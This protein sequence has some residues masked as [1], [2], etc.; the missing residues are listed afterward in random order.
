M[1][2]VIPFIVYAV[3]GT[4][5]A[6]ATVAAVATIVASIAVA[7]YE[8]KQAEEQARQ[9]YLNSLQDRLIQERSGVATRGYVVGTVRVG[10]ALLYLQPLGAKGEALDQVVAFANNECDIIDYLLSDDVISPANFPGDKYGN[11]TFEPTADTFNVTGPTATVTL[12]GVPKATHI[13]WRQNGV[14]GTG[15]VTTIAANVLGIGSLP[16]GASVVTVSYQIQEAA[17]LRGQFQSG[18][19]TQ[20][21]TA[22]AGYANPG[23]DTNHRLLGV[24]HIRTLFLWDQ[25]VFQNGAPAVTAVL[26]GRTTDGYPFYDPRDGSNPVSSTNPAIV[27]GWWMTLP[28][29]MGGMGIPTSWID[30]TT[31]AAA[32]NICDE[33]VTVRNLTNTAYESIK[34]Y[35]CDTYLDTANSPIDNLNTILSSMAGTRAFTSGLYK[36]FAGAFRPAVVTLTDSDIVG[37]K[38]ISV[39]TANVDDEPPNV[40]TA[41]ISDANQIWQQSNPTAV[42]NPDYITAD[43]YENP[44]DLTLNATTDARRARYLMGIALERGRPAF[45][46]SLSIAGVGETLGLYDTV[47][48]SLSNRSQYAG[49]TYEIVSY[50]DN[51]DGTF[52]VTLSEVKTTTF[53]LDPDTYTP[54]TP[55][56]PVDNSYLWNPPEPTTFQ[57]ASITPTT[58]PDGTAVTRVNLTWDPIPP[59]GNTPG[60][61]FDIRYRTTGGDFIDG[62]SV[63]GDSTGT[64][65]TANLQ[66][67]EQYQFELRFV[68]GLGAVSDWVDAYTPVAGT[69]LPTP[70]SM[71]ISSSSLIFRVPQTGN[72]LP[73]S[74]TLSLIR[75]G[76]LSA[77]AT[78]STSPTV[79]LGGS[80]D[81]RTLSF[82]NDTS[83]TVQ[84]TATIVQSGVTYTDVVTI[85]K[86]YDGASQ[87]ADL[88]APPTPTGLTVTAF[89]SHLLVTWDAGSFTV[90]HGYAGTVVYAAQVITG[91]T[92]P[93]FAN[94]KSI[95]SATATGLS[96][97]VDPGTTW[98]IWI[99]YETNDGVL[100][101]TPAGG[102]NGVQGT[103]ALIGTA[104]LANDLITAA[105]LADGSVGAAQLAAG[106]LDATKFAA[107]IYPVVIVASA[108]PQTNV[109]PTVYSVAQGVLYYWNGSQYSVQVQA[110]NI[111]G[112]LTDAQIATVSAAKVT[113]QIIRTQITDGAIST[114][115]LAAGVVTAANIAAN[116]IVAGNIAAGNITATLLQ[117]GAVTA[118]AIAA[119]AVTAGAISAGA[120]NATQLAAGAVTTAKLLV[121]GQGAALNDDPATSDASAWILFQANPFQIANISDG[122]AGTT[123]LRGNYSWVLSRPVTFDPTK[124]YRV[125]CQ[126]RNVGGDGVFYLIAALFDQNGVNISGD[127]TNWFYP[128]SGVVPSSAWTQYS[129]IFGAGSGRPFPSTA[130]TM[131]VGCIL[132]YV[133]STGY[134][135]CQNLRLEQ[136]IDASL[137]VDG[138]ITATKLAAN[139]IVVGT[140]AI[141]NG[142][143]VNAMIGNAAID[144]ANILELTVAKLSAGVLGADISVGAGHI[145]FDNGGVLRAQGTGFGSSNQFVDWFGVRPAG[146]NLSLCTE[147]NAGY[148][149][150]IDGSSY[151]GGSLKAGTLSTSGSTSNL[152]NNATV[153]IGPFGSNGNII[154]V[155]YSAT[156]FA[157]VENNTSAD[158]WGGGGH[159][160]LA[161]DQT[162]GSGGVTTVAT[163]TLNGT[164]STTDFGAGN[165]PRFDHRLT[166]SGSFTYTDNA[167]VAQNR[168]YT[169]R[170]TARAGVNGADIGNVGTQTLSEISVE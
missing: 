130:R 63:E 131:A 165:N 57:I 135:E 163:Q 134:M 44:L 116:T 10:G 167:R 95:G 153:T 13:T 83:D 123:A 108:P 26:A 107:G 71:R 99:K 56:T 8:K 3:A 60:A 42:T 132:N 115:Q 59:A 77:A 31:V 113:G 90:G 39:N 146:G 78:W 92:A 5:S 23:W 170:M 14:T 12:Q 16:S 7:E 54:T 126:A 85:V 151:F 156:M 47:Q 161:L 117:T 159:I 136:V 91:Q 118:N 27:A 55:V 48:L 86:V 11:Q 67:G 155:T 19:L 150:K 45:G 168:T 169:L 109:G 73:T 97:A 24:C 96:Y 145:T 89:L 110:G 133:G 144:S 34:R 46:L 87:T 141:Q 50:I 21:P 84:I 25:N 119:N 79:T 2:Q 142:A 37:T 154:T 105:K 43:G 68:N 98:A 17:K 122:I 75:T 15:T 149:L 9:S 88:T 104:N 53:A 40:V 121:T 138:S 22:W 76:G 148:Y 66:D 139:S 143:I 51:W 129:G 152:A 101:I 111:A 164:A 81:I 112:Q 18:T 36:I 125:S 35:S 124:Q 49:R 114:P 140:A 106:A 128:A 29:F 120:V 61:H 20:S 52:D 65:L 82:A 58:L 1:P 103:S 127:G 64:T 102:T 6:S 62:G 157:L 28:R 93:T 72:A 80:G 4:V 41:T 33:L 158:P 70:L 137:I 38:S 100:S 69:P 147:A 30:W 32:A 166:I 160:S 94:A 74:I 162:I